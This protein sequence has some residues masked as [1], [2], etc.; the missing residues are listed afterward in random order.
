MPFAVRLTHDAERDLEEIADYIAAQDGPARA[1]GVLAKIE[2]AI[3]SL[4]EH[5]LRGAPVRELLAVGVREYREVFLRPYRVIYRPTGKVVH[6]YLIADGRRD[7][8]SLLQRR[9]LGA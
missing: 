4:E 8:A 5:P 6:V 9:L 7:M 3:L 1:A 2:R